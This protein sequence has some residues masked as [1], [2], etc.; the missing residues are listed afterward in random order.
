MAILVTGGAGFIG[1]HLCERLLARGERVVALDNF[2]SFYPR[3]V[4]HRNLAFA[5]SKLDFSLVEGDVREAADLDRA[6]A[7]AGQPITEVIHLAALVGVRPSLHEPER[8]FSVNLMG[9][10]AVLAACERA[11]VRRVLVASSSSVYGQSSTPPFRESDACD[12]PLSPYAASKRAAE[13]YAFSFQQRTG[14]AVTCLRF[15]TVFGPRQRP[16]LAIHKFTAAIAAGQ[17]IELYG[18]G[19]SARDYTYVDDIVDGVIAALV[20]GRGDD[21]GVGFH[22]YNLGGARTTSL[23]RLAELVAHTVGKPAQIHWR[24]EQPG[25]MHETLAN[26]DLS[27][28]E[29]GYAPKVGIEEGLARF[30]SWFRAQP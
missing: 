6:F 9:T 17:P 24:A 22:I 19:S 5:R 4:K 29:L 30:V 25:D 12:R 2:D 26:L 15:F 21:T 27:A 18:D 20:R 14:T 28:R 7:A 13:L 16:D 10:L 1:S 3:A 11:G 23:R 8:Y